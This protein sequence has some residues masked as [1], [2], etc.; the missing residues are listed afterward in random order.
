[1]LQQDYEHNA[2]LYEY[3]LQ[4]AEASASTAKA[5][6]IAGISTG[7]IN[8]FANLGNAAANVISSV[9]GLGSTSTIT[10]D[11]VE[12]YSDYDKQ[13]NLIHTRRHELHQ[14]DN[15]Q[16]EKLGK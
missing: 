13:G 4:E 6:Q 3:E 7:F 11:L 8:S 1:M 16:N 5:R 10:K 9:Y 14:S 2:G 15:S 12:E